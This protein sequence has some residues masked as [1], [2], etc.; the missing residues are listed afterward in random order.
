MNDTNLRLDQPAWPT[1]V[2]TWYPLF[3]WQI[4]F[5]GYRDDLKIHAGFL[6]NILAKSK[7]REMTEKVTTTL[8][9]HPLQMYATVGF[10]LTMK[11]TNTHIFY[12][13]LSEGC[14]TQ[15]G[16][17]SSSWCFSSVHFQNLTYID[18]NSTPP[19][20]RFFSPK[21]TPCF[22]VSKNCGSIFGADASRPLCLNSSSPL[23][24]TASTLPTFQR[25]VWS[26]LHAIRDTNFKSR[27]TT[28]KF[29]LFLKNTHGWPPQPS[30]VSFWHEGITGSNV[31]LQEGENGL[32]LILSSRTKEGWTKH[33]WWSN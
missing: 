8:K 19:K 31:D 5:S 21:K 29:G 2:L 4:I 28:W 32:K 12:I 10:H 17:H 30:V 3:P 11:Q 26:F 18:Q 25:P 24:P 13:K 7:L 23:H 15:V 22:E 1:K 20:N 6:P 9:S 16:N 27:C 14:T 33:I